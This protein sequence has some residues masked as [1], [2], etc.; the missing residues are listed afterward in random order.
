MATN[1]NELQ[2]RFSIIIS[3]PGTQFPVMKKKYAMLYK[4]TILL[5]LYQSK[6]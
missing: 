6:V 3:Y 4:N 5:L 2:D 1:C